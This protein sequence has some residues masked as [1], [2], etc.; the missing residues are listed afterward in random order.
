MRFREFTF[1]ALFCY[2]MTSWRD[3]YVSPDANSGFERTLGDFWV[4]RRTIRRDSECLGP[5]GNNAF[6][7]SQVPHS[8]KQTFDGALEETKG[9]LGA[10][11]V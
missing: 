7:I 11:E 2:F 3:E 8:D 1:R 9:I 6:S 10:K 5:A 4:H